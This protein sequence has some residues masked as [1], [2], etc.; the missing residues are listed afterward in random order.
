MSTKKKQ[1]TPVQDFD[2]L[3]LPLISEIARQALK[4]IIADNQPAIPPVYEK[5]FFNMAF[6][7]WVSRN[8]S[9]K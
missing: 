7:A 8:W 2:K 5:A 1:T 6:S 9:A 4:K 3:P